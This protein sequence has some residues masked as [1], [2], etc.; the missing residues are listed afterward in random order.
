MDEGGGEGMKGR[1]HNSEGGPT[2]WLICLS[3]FAPAAGRSLLV[4]ALFFASS[5]HPSL[6]PSLSSPFSFPS[7][8]LTIGQHRL[9][10]SIR[11]NGLFYV[12]RP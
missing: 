5:L 3:V 7:F 9:A 6:R 8:G 2:G 12:P 1:Q 4:T 10:P 11:P